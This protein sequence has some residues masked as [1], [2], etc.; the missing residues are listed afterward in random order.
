MQNLLIEAESIIDESFIPRV[1]SFNRVSH[2]Q[3]ANGS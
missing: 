3:L 2:F 1:D